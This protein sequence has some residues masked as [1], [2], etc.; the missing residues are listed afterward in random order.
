MGTQN[1]L[2]I[3]GTG[4]V[5]LDSTTGV[6]T[7][8]AIPLNGANGGTG[9]ANTGLTVDLASGATGKVLTSDSSGNATWQV[10]GFPSAPASSNTATAAF[11]QIA[12]GT[13][14]QN[15][16]GYA[17]NIIFTAQ[18]TATTGLDI[19][20]GVGSTNTP[21]T[22]SLINYGGFVSI[23]EYTS[24]TI[25]LPNNYYVLFTTNA[26]SVP[27]GPFTVVTPL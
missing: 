24:F 17:V 12:F 16:L 20:V 26:A 25:C 9:V 8:L 6:F 10:A 27:V 2:N 22:D 3:N 7:E 4:I 14:K 13:A 5:S 15:T 1:S 21:T 18:Y 11:G 23:N 19:S